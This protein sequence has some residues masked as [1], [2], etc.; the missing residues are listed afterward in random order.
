MISVHI[1]SV[2]I[3]LIMLSLSLI[4]I[5]SRR[6]LSSCRMIENSQIEPNVPVFYKHHASRFSTNRTAFVAGS[7][8]TIRIAFGSLSGLAKR[9]RH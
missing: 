2:G 3:S 4:W 9:A 6:S 7:R 1:E 8:G 5:S